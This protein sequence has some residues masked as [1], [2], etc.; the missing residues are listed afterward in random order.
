MAVNPPG[1]VVVSLFTVSVGLDSVGRSCKGLLFD[2]GGCKGFSAIGESI[3]REI[4]GDGNRSGVT[5]GCWIGGVR[6]VVGVSI[7]DFG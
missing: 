4:S 6:G 5:G 7:S 3:D 2:G 1:I